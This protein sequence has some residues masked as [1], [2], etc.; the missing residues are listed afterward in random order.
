[1]PLRLVI[2]ARCKE[3]R[4][5]R[6]TLVVLSRPGGF[7]TRNCLTCGKPNAVQFKQLPEDLVCER[8]Q[9][10]VDPT[11]NARG[12]YA[13]SCSCCGSL[14]ELAGLVPA[15]QNEFLYDGFGLDGDERFYAV[16]D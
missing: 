1:M 9:V 11:T 6:D 12:N 14:S 13:Y 15:W 2:Y 4:A 16:D 5:L 8:C 10:Q 3:C 7:V